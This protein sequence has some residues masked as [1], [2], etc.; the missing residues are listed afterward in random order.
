M[1]KPNLSKYTKSVLAS[2]DKHSPEILMGVGIAGMFTTTILAVKATPKAL[3]LLEQKKEE[4]ETDKLTKIDM[5][6][7][8][9]KC[10]IPAAATGVLST[11]CIIGSNS[12]KSKRT[13]ALAT[14]YKISETALTEYREKVIETIGEKKEKEIVDKIA[15]DDVDKNPVTK[16]EVVFVDKGGELC[17]D[18]ISGRYFYSDRNKIDRAQ[19]TLNAKI[20]NENYV[21]LNEFYDE[22]GL[23]FTDE[24]MNLGWNVDNLIDIYYS[25]QEADNGEVCRVIKHYNPPK[26]KYY[27]FT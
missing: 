26:Y 24:G 10:Y 22:I 27:S 19:N 13:A 12:V 4:L 25:Y 9:Y 11:I 8:T 6:K 1:K 5:V 14:A 18:P 23:P 16:R 3:I 20:I 17:L 2:L 15:K 7:T 21:S